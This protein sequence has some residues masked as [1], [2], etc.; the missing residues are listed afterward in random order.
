MDKLIDFLNK[1]IK[2]YLTKLSQQEMSPKQLHKEFEFLLR[3]NDLENIGDIVDKSIMDLVQKNMK[4]GYV[5]SNEGWGEIISFHALVVECL[6]LSTA[7]FN[8]RDEALL[9]RLT[10]SYQQIEAMMFQL[11]KMHVQRLHQGVKESVDTTSVH[12]DLL[13]HLQRIAALSVNFTKLNEATEAAVFPQ[14]ASA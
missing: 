11:S 1:G 2:L 13:G 6:G 5:F 10:Q 14:P 8:S 3:T 9:N 4:K 12:L 7:Y